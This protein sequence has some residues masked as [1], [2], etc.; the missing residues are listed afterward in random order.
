MGQILERDEAHYENR[1]V[2]FGKV[3]EWHPAS[4]ALECDCG[5]QVTL[6]A[7]FWCEMPIS[8]V[9]TPMKPFEQPLRVPSASCGLPRYLCPGYLPQVVGQ[10]APSYP[11]L[12]P[13]FSVIEAQI[14]PEGTS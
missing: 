13:F 12:H 2:P 14:Q 3:Y 7:S 5:E 9:R 11:S 1:E 8:M 10:D 4:V 6:S